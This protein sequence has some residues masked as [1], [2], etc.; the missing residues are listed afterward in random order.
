MSID[1]FDRTFAGWTVEWH[2]NINL[3]VRSGLLGAKGGP[4]F[5]FSG[6]EVRVCTCTFGVLV[7]GPRQRGGIFDARSQVTPDKQTARFL[8]RPVRGAR[9]TSETA[10]GSRKV[11]S[12]LNG[13][14]RWSWGGRGV[15]AA[16]LDKRAYV[17]GSARSGQV[18][19]GVRGG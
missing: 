3:P 4:K 8:S 19:H 14:K 18:G 13:P 16:L 9:M 17:G 11:H 12:V 2:P 1:F 6:I 15:L 10:L 7:G 5:L